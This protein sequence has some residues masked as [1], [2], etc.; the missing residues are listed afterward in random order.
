MLAFIE[1]GSLDLSSRSGSRSA[2][3]S[4]AARAPRHHAHNCIR[5]SE[6][7]GA[8]ADLAGCS[9][10]VGECEL[11]SASPRVNSVPPETDITAKGVGVPLISVKKRVCSWGKPTSSPGIDQHTQTRQ[12]RFSSTSASASSLSRSRR[13]GRTPGSWFSS[14]DQ[15][16]SKNADPRIL[17]SVPRDEILTSTGSMR[18]RSRHSL[19]I[20]LEGRP[21]RPA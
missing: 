16:C 14:Y 19:P 4:N 12:T 21:V 10:L 6:A 5:A 15:R 11:Y 7:G 17:T 18:V 2:Q 3:A 8:L 9:L 1:P 13:R 20:V